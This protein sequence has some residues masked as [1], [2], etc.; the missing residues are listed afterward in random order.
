[1]KGEVG[2]AIKGGLILGEVG[3]FMIL[4]TCELSFSP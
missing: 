4:E 1:M 2:L 3:V